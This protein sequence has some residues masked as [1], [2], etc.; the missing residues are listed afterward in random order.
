M[1][2]II[3]IIITVS[4]GTATASIVLLSIHDS[5]SKPHVSP[6]PDRALWTLTLETGHHQ[7][8]RLPP[9]S[10]PAIAASNNS[11]NQPKLAS[12]RGRPV[13]VPLSLVLSPWLLLNKGSSLPSPPPP[14]QICHP[15]PAE[16]GWDLTG[17][18]HRQSIPIGDRRGKKQKG[19]EGVKPRQ[20]EGN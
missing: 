19:R 13:R 11:Q 16:G 2:I 15:V 3:I 10:T 18:S 8:N 1:I 14:P 6:P 5:P 9:P 4:L 17:I 7:C 20:K 12:V